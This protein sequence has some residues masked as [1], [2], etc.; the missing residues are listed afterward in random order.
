MCIPIEERGRNLTLV[1]FVDPEPARTIGLVWRSTTPRRDDFEELGRLV[2]KAAT[3][4]ALSAARS[5][6]KSKKAVSA[7]TT[8]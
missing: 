5:S 6:S 1:R 4:G 2:K 3:E 7:T 8:S